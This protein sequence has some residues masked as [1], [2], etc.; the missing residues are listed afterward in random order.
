VFCVTA[1]SIKARGGR[2]VCKLAVPEKGVVMGNPEDRIVINE[3]LGVEILSEFSLGERK[4]FLLKS[5][6][7]FSFF[8]IDD[9]SVKKTF[10]MRTQQTVTSKWM[11]SINPL[12]TKR[13]CFI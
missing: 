5:T 8:V 2:Y 13:I 6:S 3:E 9:E 4:I 7:R 12:K 11:V 10:G 1:R